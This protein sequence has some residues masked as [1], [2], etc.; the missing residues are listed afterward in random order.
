ME[1]FA[2]I[3]VALSIP[4]SRVKRP[5]I[6]RQ[7]KYVLMDGAKSLCV[8]LTKIVHTGK[9]VKKV[10]VSQKF[11]LRMRNVSMD[12]NVRK[13]FVFL[14]N[15]ERISHVPTNSYARMDNVLRSHV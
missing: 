8:P 10:C 14:R 4:L 3:G 5:T 12:L 6:V 11:A 9:S 13:R 7:E 2:K 1:I 15:V